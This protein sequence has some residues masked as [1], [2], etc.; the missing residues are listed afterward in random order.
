MPPE[1]PILSQGEADKNLAYLHKSA[2]L[3]REIEKASTPLEGIIMPP[4]RLPPVRQP[5]LRQKLQFDENQTDSAAEIDTD[6]A[7]IIEL[8]EKVNEKN[9]SLEATILDIDQQICET[10][11]TDKPELVY[12][13]R[14]FLAVRNVDNGFWLCQAVQDVYRGKSR[15]RI[16]WLTFSSTNANVYQFEYHGEIEFGCILTNINLE[17]LKTNRFRLVDSEKE[18][19]EDIL[20]ESLAAEANA[21]STA[22]QEMGEV[23][24]SPQQGETLSQRLN[25]ADSAVELT[26]IREHPEREKSE[27]DRPNND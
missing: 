26:E 1:E 5:R 8:P 2:N 16:Q 11:D 12:R 19:I 22:F 17:K 20:R 3:C 27:T 23:T 13:K 21:Q 10:R 24:N 18:R 25:N 6:L 15:N 7:N 14:E 9:K 4:P